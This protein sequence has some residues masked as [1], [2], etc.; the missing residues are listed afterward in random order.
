MVAL[1]VNSNYGFARDF[2]QII[3]YR[4]RNLGG[5]DAMAPP[6]FITSQ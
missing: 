1:V 6:D 3:I 4:C 2:V 5:Q